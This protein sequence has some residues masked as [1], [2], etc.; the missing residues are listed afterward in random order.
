MSTAR[1]VR[2][3]T[4]RR[5]NKIFDKLAIDTVDAPKTDGKGGQLAYEIFDI[6]DDVA[7]RALET[8]F[9]Q[10]IKT[11]RLDPTEYGGY[12]VQDAIYCYHGRV[13]DS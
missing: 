4:A 3:W 10:G 5:S 9:I 11:G 7:K 2:T 6:N 13:G 1:A 12:T 8:K